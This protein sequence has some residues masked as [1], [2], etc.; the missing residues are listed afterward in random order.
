MI[1]WMVYSVITGALIVAAARAADSVARL[2][3]W[4]VR[5]GWAAAIVLTVA[6]SV[7]APLRR[8]APAVVAP[9]AAVKA[10][11][12]PL[13]EGIELVN[14]Q[15]PPSTPWLITLTWI[16]VSA[17]F[18]VVMVAVHARLRAA[19]RAWPL[20]D[21]HGTRVRISPQTGPAVVGFSKPEIVVPRW[22]LGRTTEEQRLI[23]AHEEEHVAARD[24]VLLGG[25]CVLVAL[26]PWNPALWYAF[27]RLRLAVELDCDARVLGR[28]DIAARSYGALLID[29]A[30]YAPRLRFGVAALANNPSHLHQRILAMKRSIPK[31]ARLRG[32]VVSVFGVAALVAACEAKMPTSAEVERMDLGA[33]ESRL[34]TMTTLAPD[35]AAVY[36]VDL[37]EVTRTEALALRPEEIAS[38]EVRKVGAAK[39]VLITKQGVAVPTEVPRRDASKSIVL[40]GSAVEG[41]EPPLVLIDGV[42]ADMGAFRKLDPESIESVEVL[43]G[44]AAIAVYGDSA[45]RGVIAIKTKTGI[46]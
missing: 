37:K 43:K 45:T 3:R 8:P 35:S 31:F 27:S 17:L 39:K 7:V 13:D 1:G 21:L 44:K 22:L 15:L 10:T 26:M 32:G 2:V 36:L 18:V 20:T 46:R 34:A 14:Q 6:V 19:R 9:T 28:G 24:T 12:L 11:V 16:G 25:A 33:A 41:T 4:P 40:R 29:V 23:V 38:V 30:E 5:W 42:H